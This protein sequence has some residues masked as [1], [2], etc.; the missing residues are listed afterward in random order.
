[1][2]KCARVGIADSEKGFLSSPW[3]IRV[4]VPFLLLLPLAAE[5]GGLDLCCALAVRG[6]WLGV[7]KA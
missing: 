2:G 4:H 1:M 5:T 6:T 7:I 3:S